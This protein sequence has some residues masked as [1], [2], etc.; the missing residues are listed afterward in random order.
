MN[1]STKRRS[2][3]ESGRVND[4][5][6]WSYIKSLKTIIFFVRLRENQSKVDLN[7]FLGTQSVSF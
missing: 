2:R 1:D 5:T 3:S 7:V 4:R 6:S